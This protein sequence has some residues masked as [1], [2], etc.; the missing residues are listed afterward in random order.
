[1]VWNL[2]LLMESVKMKLLSVADCSRTLTVKLI[3]MSMFFL[4]YTVS[5]QGCAEGQRSWLRVVTNI[6][7]ASTFFVLF[8]SGFLLLYQIIIIIIKV[9]FSCQSF[10]PYND[11]CNKDVWA[12]SSYTDPSLSQNTNGRYFCVLFQF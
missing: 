6:S 2:N 8:L 9:D 12:S 7:P 3:D 5:L 1:M 4:P 11:T 10:S